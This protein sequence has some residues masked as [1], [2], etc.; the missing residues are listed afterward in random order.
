MKIKA[1]ELLCYNT[2]LSVHFSAYIHIFLL[3]F[4]TGVVR[5]A[6]GLNNTILQTIECNRNVKNEVSLLNISVDN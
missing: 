2:F 4:S 3:K 6:I 1:F 5:K